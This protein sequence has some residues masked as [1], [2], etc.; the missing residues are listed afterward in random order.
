VS[1]TGSAQY[2]IP[3]W[4]PPGVH[5]VQPTLALVYDSNAGYGIM[6][7]GWNLA[8]LSTISRCNRTY[9]QDGV[10]AAVTLNYA[11]A[12]CLDGSRLR[13]TSSDSLGT[14]GNASTTYQTEIANFSNVIASS[15]LDGNGPA[16]FEVQG[17]NGL[18]YEYGNTVSSLEI[19][20]GTSTPYAWAL[21][22]VTDRAGNYMTYAYTQIDGAFV[23]ASIKYT[24]ANG[25]STFLYTITFAYTTKSPA[26]TKSGYLAG[27]S[28]QQTQ[29]LKSIT[30]ATSGGTNL[31]QY[32]LTYSTSSN[33]QRALLTS[34]QECGGSALT[35]CLPATTMLN[36]SSVPTYQSGAAGFT[37]PTTSTGSTGSV[38]GSTVTSIDIDGDGQQDL[39]YATVSGSTYTWYVQF[40]TASGYSAPVPVGF[41][42]TS[43]SANILVDRFEGTQQND[44]LVPSGSAWVEY[45]W[46]GGYYSANPSAGF[47][48]TPVGGKY[49]SGL[50]YASADVNGDGLA[51]IVSL[52]GS[53]FGS[54][55]ITIVVNA[56]INTKGGSAHFASPSGALY[57]LNLQQP[58]NTTQSSTIGLIGNNWFQNTPVKK[59]D[60]DGDGRDDLLSVYQTKTYNPTSKTYTFNYTTIMLF[61]RGTAG[62]AAQGIGDIIYMPVNWNDDSCTDLV[63]SQAVYLSACA[64]ITPANIALGGIVP[65]LAL[66]WDGDGRTDLLAKNASG[67]WEVYISTGSGISSGT[68]TSIPVGSGPYV[69]TDQNGD[70]LDDVVNASASPLL[71]GLHS[72]A[73]QKADLLTLITDGYGNTFSPTYASLVGAGNYTEFYNTATFPYENY[74][75]PLYAVSQAT[76]SDPSNQPGGTYYQDYSYFGGWMNLQG[77][78]FAGFAATAMSDS[79]YV[80]PLTPLYTYEY[81]EQSFPYTG[82]HF[83]EYVDYLNSGNVTS[84]SQWVGAPA[85]TTLD[86]TANNERYFPYLS[87]VVTDQWELG[88]TEATDLITATSTTYTYDT[89]GN[90]TE[91]VSTITDSDPGSPWT[92]DTWTTTTANTIS[93]YDTST[94]CLNMPT[95]TQIQYYSTAPGVT[96]VTRQI[97]YTPDYT[98]CRETVKVTAPSTAY[99]VTETY[100]FD[101]FGNINSDAVTGTGMAARTTTVNWG[102]TGQFPTV[103]TNPLSQSITL[104]FDTKTGMK[105]SQTDPNYTSSNPIE[106][107]WGY[108]DFGRKTKETRPDGTYTLWSYGTCSNCAA[109]VRMEVLEEMYDNTGNEITGVR[110]QLRHAGSPARKH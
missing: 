103:I 49:Q 28:V 51:D 70:G 12:F 79:R 20:P 48:S 95:E 64:G 14:Y 56:Q 82:M 102:T 77:R 59:M 87:N 101:G 34:L 57:T 108:D 13:L 2:S 30:I 84:L 6:G 52:S 73:G 43:A 8:G 58:T 83:Q 7:P 29:Q 63:G 42:T 21:D 61:S 31:R 44:I 106:T 16:Y 92:G 47:E 89:Y 45:K 104:G 24:A 36:S 3:L 97:N 71:Y 69:V 96:S 94:W 25:S 54:T 65:L 99:Q 46:N 11:D 17:K 19:V 107:T 4:V 10:P 76:F 93:E 37:N 38:V 66:D 15:T 23:P 55:T 75:G 81:Y 62:M 110:P 53:A 74:I 98:N 85:V 9:A 1:Q 33:T 80:A 86:S 68:A 105:T 50:V 22:K 67:D 90:A 35:D 100:G 78:G 26:D 72:G 27:A 60:F 91:V 88:G 109:I 32:N 18:T 39:L 41:T 5:G 40:A